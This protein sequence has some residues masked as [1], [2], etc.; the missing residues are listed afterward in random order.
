MALLISATTSMVS[1]IEMTEN[2][3]DRTVIR[4]KDIKINKPLDDSVFKVH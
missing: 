4:F 2:N 3:G 1:E